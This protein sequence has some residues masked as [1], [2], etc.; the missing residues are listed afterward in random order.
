MN[1]PIDFPPDWFDARQTFVHLSVPGDGDWRETAIAAMRSCPAL[2]SVNREDMESSLAEV[3]RENA[4][5]LSKFIA[6]GSLLRGPL[7][8][9]VDADEIRDSL[10]ARML[11]QL[12]G[13]ARFWTNHGGAEDGQ[14]SGYLSSSFHVNALAETTIDLCLIGVSPRAVLV[15]WRFEDD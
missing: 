6:F 8:S 7:Q 15:L 9:L 10:L 4:L 12:G 3:S 11:D 13:D 14:E 2:Q 1:V 5:D